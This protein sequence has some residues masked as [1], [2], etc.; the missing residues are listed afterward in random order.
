MSLN[1]HNI[2]SNPHIG[3]FSYYRDMPLQHTIMRFQIPLLLLLFCNPG[4]YTDRL[5]SFLAEFKPSHSAKHLVYVWKPYYLREGR[6]EYL[7][8]Y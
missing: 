7:L 8:G 4:I 3:N 6:L 1:A 5:L 2:F